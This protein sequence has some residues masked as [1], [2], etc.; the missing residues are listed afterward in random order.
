M[1][2]YDAPVWFWIFM[3]SAL[4]VMTGLNGMWAVGMIKIA[5]GLGGGDKKKDKKE[6]KKEKKWE[7]MN[8]TVVN[9]PLYL[10][11]LLLPVD[12][13]KGKKE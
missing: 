11:V 3:S 5:L 7:R 12:K 6:K 9:W 8:V 1:S 2:N 4:L 13:E 10:P